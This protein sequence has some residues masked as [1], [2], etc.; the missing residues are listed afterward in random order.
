MATSDL[1]ARRPLPLSWSAGW[2]RVAEALHL[3]TLLVLAVGLA[4]WSALSDRFGAYLVP[5]PSRVLVGLAGIVADGQLWVHVGAS[6]YRIGLGFGG[7]VAVSLLAG[8]LAAGLP[9]ARTVLRDLTAILNST[10]VF[11]WIVLATIWFGLSDRGPVFTTFMIVLPVMLSNVGEGVDR[12]DRKLLEM[13]QV[14]RLSGLDRFRHVTLPSTVPYLVAGMK[15]A[16]ALGLR[17]SVVAE[18]FGVSAGIGYA[19]NFS[20]DTLRTD[21]VFAWAL[22]LIA[23]MV[24]AEKIVFETLSRRANAWR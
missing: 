10:S 7:A 20:R 8:L 15:V 22:V 6:L 4:I 3:P 21:M 12:V 23:V 9:A 13:A 14:Y 1:P 16:F 5:P 2:R 24:L 19:M 18:L 17:V 11:V